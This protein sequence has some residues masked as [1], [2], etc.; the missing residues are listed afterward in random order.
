M[1]A[2]RSA[3]RSLVETRW[4]DARGRSL[5]RV[6]LPARSYRREHIVLLAEAEAEALIRN[7]GKRLAERSG[8][9]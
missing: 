1:S 8:A 6:W 7:L 9:A 2:V 5:I 4:D 3:R